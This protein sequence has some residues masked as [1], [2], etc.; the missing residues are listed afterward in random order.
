MAP[1]STQSSPTDSILLCKMSKTAWRL[2]RTNS[3]QSRVGPLA[4]PAPARHVTRHPP[5]TAMR[6]LPTVASRSL[7]WVRCR[8]LQSDIRAACPRPKSSAPYSAAPWTFRTRW[9]A[10]ASVWS[11][12]GGPKVDICRKVV[13]VAREHAKWFLDD[14]GQKL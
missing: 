8:H 10:R 13:S 3:P 7:Q 6:V 11:S 1:R 4:S 5:L 14:A 9:W 12:W 2:D